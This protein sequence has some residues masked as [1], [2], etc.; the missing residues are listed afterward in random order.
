MADTPITSEN[1]AGIFGT[2]FT[3]ETLTVVVGVLSIQ[4]QID[5]LQRQIVK[6]RQDQQTEIAERNQVI[7][8]LQ[9]QID[10]L[11]TQLIAAA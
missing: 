10:I 6:A 7:A 5:V 4:A 9:A 3:V 11:N 8:D 1:L 2:L